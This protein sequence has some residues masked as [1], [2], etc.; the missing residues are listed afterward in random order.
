MGQSRR[1][2]ITTFNF[3]VSITGLA[4]A[5]CS[6]AFDGNFAQFETSF[7]QAGVPGAFMSSMDM[8]TG[9]ELTHT[10]GYDP[11]GDQIFRIAS[12]TKTITTVAALQLVDRGLLTLDDPLEPILP[13]LAEIQILGP[14]CELISPSEPITLR[15][16]LS[17]TSG[18]AYAFDSER[19]AA[20][21]VEM[22]WNQET[23]RVFESGAGFIYGRGVGWAGLVIEE[24]SGLKLEQYVRENISGPLGLDR[25]WFD[26]P[27]ELQAEIVD[28]GFFAVD[29]SG[30][31]YE[32][33]FE[34]FQDRVPLSPSSQYGGGDMFSSPNDFK[35][36]LVMLAN[37]G[38]LD[39]VRILSPELVEEMFRNQLPAGV[40]RDL[41]CIEPSLCYP[42]SLGSS[43]D[44]F[45]LGIALAATSG[46]RA[47]RKG[48]WGGLFNSYFTIDY[49]R[50]IVVVYFSQYLPYADPRAYG[51]YQAFERKVYET[52]RR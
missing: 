29:N 5:S 36:F 4:L 24:V 42:P 32:D 27:E 20:C 25:T 1:H 49:D 35:R 7:E 6:P 48:Y 9:K 46:G 21:G 15:H 19:H 40:T 26:V 3:L 43:N 14:D 50:K 31:G 34:V 33:K 45:G 17:H 11:S 41:T 2:D 51:L 13:V 37:E 22:G 47:T 23:P 10:I 39:G 30:S 18:F 28:Y 16:L 38:E 44:L 52:D 12:M 8:K